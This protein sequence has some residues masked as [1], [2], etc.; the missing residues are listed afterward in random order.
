MKRRLA[1]VERTTA[2]IRQD[3]N[4]EVAQR[5]D[6][7]ARTQA[8]QQAILDGLRVE[9]QSI[10]GRFDDLARERAE[11]RDE[12]SLMR[13]DLALKITAMEDRLNKLQA[14]PLRHR[15]RLRRPQQNPRKPLTNEG[16]S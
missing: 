12:L 9:L 4:R 10:A 1:E 2:T 16:L 8:D 11:T 7:L 5:L 3:G 15:R 14:A 6:A 13:D